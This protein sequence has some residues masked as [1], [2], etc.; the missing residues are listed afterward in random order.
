M[1]Q[2]TRIRSVNFYRVL[3]VVGF[4][5]AISAVLLVRSYAF[6]GPSS[7]GGI[8]SGALYVGPNGNIALGTSSAPNALTI[9]NGSIQITSSSAG[10]IFPD[11]SMQTTA[12]SSSGSGSGTTLH[13]QIFTSN[14]TWMRPAGVT[15]V[16]ATVCAGGGGGGMGYNDS[17]YYN[18]YGGGGGGS[19][20]CFIEDDITGITGNVP[21]T[22]GAGGARGDSS[23]NDGNGQNGGDS[24]FG[25]FVTAYGGFGGGQAAQAG[26]GFG[27]SSYGNPGHA[28]SSTQ[29]WVG[30]E[31]GTVY[32]Q[33][34]VGGTPGASP[35]DSTTG[36][37][38]TGGGGA[39][40][41]GYVGF[42]GS[43]GKVKIEW[44]Q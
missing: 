8:G 34:G 25:T 14:G 33:F 17:N 24:S 32:Q 31:V 20:G 15:E 38:G 2:D 4:A 3:A 22:I 10:I 26:P 9:A 27:G 30:C 23:S 13:R 7:Q 28:G 18:G 43:P 16:W 5:A 29:G 19:G 12:A 6:N 39:C 37:G 21:I 42:A 41:S 36:A 40:G 44:I 35:L 1:N 11:G